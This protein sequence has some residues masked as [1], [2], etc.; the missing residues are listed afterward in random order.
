MPLAELL[1]R[2]A[3]SPAEGLSEGEADERLPRFRA[4]RSAARCVSRDLLVLAQLKSLLIVI[5]TVAAA[6]AALVGNIKDAS[7]ILAVVVFNAALGFYLLPGVS[8]R[9]ESR[10]TSGPCFR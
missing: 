3:V 8:R 6:H 1:H 5:L 10:G 4:E 7:V 2:L 9:T